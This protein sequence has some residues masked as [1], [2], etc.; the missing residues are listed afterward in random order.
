MYQDWWAVWHAA[1]QELGWKADVGRRLLEF[2][3]IA[4]GGFDPSDFRK[5]GEG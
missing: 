2:R 3:D 4:A 5:E 1:W